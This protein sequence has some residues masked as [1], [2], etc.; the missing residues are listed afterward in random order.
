MPG[1]F[2]LFDGASDQAHSL[3]G[4][5]FII[6]KMLFIFIY[7]GGPG[8]SLACG[9][10]DCGTRDLVALGVQSLSPWTAREVPGLPLYHTHTVWLGRATLPT[11]EVTVAIRR[12]RGMGEV[13][14]AVEH[15]ADASC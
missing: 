15:Y 8:L 2:S 13:C 14:R 9:I 1:H 4:I 11:L 10:F 12:E 6:F 5:H 3:C 7:L